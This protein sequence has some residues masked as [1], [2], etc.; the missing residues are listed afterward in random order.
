MR[1]ADGHNDGVAMPATPICRAPF[2][3]FDKEHCRRHA[4]GFAAPFSHVTRHLGF[5]LVSKLNSSLSTMTTDPTQLDE[6]SRYLS[7][8][9]R[10]EPQTIGLQLNTEGWADID[11]LIAGA[12]R[13]GRAIDQAMIRAVVETS[14]KKRFALSDDCRRIRAV[15][16]HST[17]TV[18][19]TYPETIPP[20][21]L[22]HGT[23]TRFLASIRE[24]GLK[25]GFRHH[26]HLSL[27]VSTA[28]TVGKRHGKPVVLEIRA[29]RMHQN[30]FKFFLSENN[31]WLTDAVPPEFI[32]TID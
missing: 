10:H 27:D 22:Y 8:V 7:Y 25:A 11:S 2:L 4:R 32:N 21:M 5:D 16:G 12:S 3:G 6:L 28:T 20:E 29:L 26:V 23:A 31:V 24:Q 9:L 30:G 15:Q 1:P 17:S 13:H 14:K 18:Q 19:R